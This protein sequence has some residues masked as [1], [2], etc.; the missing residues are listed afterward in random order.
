MGSRD[1]FVKILLSFA[2][3]VVV[4]VSFG[5]KQRI[6]LTVDKA[7][8]EGYEVPTNFEQFINEEFNELLYSTKYDWRVEKV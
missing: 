4:L 8:F 1:K 5:G 2:G 7:I 6:A 3:A